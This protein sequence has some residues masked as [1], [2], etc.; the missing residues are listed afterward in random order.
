MNLSGVLALLALLAAPTPGPA[1]HRIDGVPYLRQDRFLCGP[2][3]LGMVLGHWGVIVPQQRLA[4]EI[5]LGK[6]EGSLNLDLLAAARR[7]GFAAAMHRGSLKLLK[8][9]LRRDIPV[10]ALI[11]VSAEPERYHY[12]VVFGY[13]DESQTLAVHSGEKRDGDVSYREFERDW[14][15]ADRWMLTVERKEDL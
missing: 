3:C 15:A 9:F 12:L 4:E 8:D 11:R 6:L 14:E 1:R 7:H 5:Y 2:A 13:D 10:I